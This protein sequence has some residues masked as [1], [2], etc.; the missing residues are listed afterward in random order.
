MQ[1]L[2]CLAASIQASLGLA[3]VAFSSS[4]TSLPWWLPTGDELLG[5]PSGNWLKLSSKVAGD[6]G[7]ALGELNVHTANGSL[8]GG[9][10]A[11]IDGSNQGATL[12][13]EV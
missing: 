2:R 5:Y 9:G 4:T 3:P 13:L 8:T 7:A 12:F 11:L 10:W 6:C 1:E